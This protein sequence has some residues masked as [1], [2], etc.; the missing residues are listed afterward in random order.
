ME[1]SKVFVRLRNRN[2]DLLF[3]CRAC[4]YYTKETL[5]HTYMKQRFSSSHDYVGNKTVN[6]A[7]NYGKID[8]EDGGPQNLIHLH[9]S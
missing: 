5:S 6:V 3:C 4:D 9:H 7:V 2:Q 8:D 1:K